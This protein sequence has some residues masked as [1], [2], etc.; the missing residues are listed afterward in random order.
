M[1]IIVDDKTKVIVQGITGEQGKF[2]TG[3]MMEYGTKIVSGVT[4]GKGGQSVNGVP[5]FN[6]VSE[7]LKFS[8][9]DFS[10]IFVP[11]PKAL[12]AAME[13][14][15]AGLNLVIITEHIPVRDTMAIVAKAKSKG[16]IVIGPNCPGVI[17]PGECKIGIM[18]GHIFTR[19]N[20]GIVSRSGT[21]TYEIV[22]NLSKNNFG[23]STVVGIGGDFINGINYIETLEKFQRDEETKIIVLIGE[24]GGEA[25]ER[26]AEYIKNNVTKPV[27][28]YIAGR[29]APEGKT[30][31]HAGAIISGSSGSYDSKVSVLK[32][33]G[34]EVVDFPWEMAKA[35]EKFFLPQ[36]FGIR[37]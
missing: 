9:A 12:G 13:S 5:V 3:L 14:L 8:P 10:A 36:N 25:E 20:V 22:D 24:I 37:N 31:G 7:S 23:Q 27:V 35:L 33:A 2:H 4:P 34:V 21:L 18:P 6:S 17:T 15:D 11:A 28:A 30:M 19:G 1:S 26:A 32:S 29:A 16:L